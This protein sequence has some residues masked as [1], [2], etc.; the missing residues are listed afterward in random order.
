MSPVGESDSASEAEWGDLAPGQ[1]A[2]PV[3]VADGQA[4][5][6]LDALVSALLQGEPRA[7][8]RAITVVENATDDAARVLAAVAGHGDQVEVVGITGPPGAGKS[9]LTDALVTELRRRGRRVAV[10][11]VDPS[12]PLSGGAILGDRIRMLRHAEDEGVFVR[13]VAS[14]GHLGGLFQSVA[15]VLQ[16][17]AASGVDVVIVETVGAGQS[18]VEITRFAKT[19]VVVCDPGHGDDIQAMKAGILEIA[20]V[21]VVNKGDQ[22]GAQETCRQLQSMV[23]LRDPNLGPVAVLT[24]TATTGQGVAELVDAL[25]VPGQGSESGGGHKS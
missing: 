3:P 20:D 22:P 10:L 7:L 23:H 15:G 25:H 12:S 24:T 5:D 13:S 14:R 21:L 2:A 9:T 8:A 6:S 1:C 17:M 18:E 16:V 4:S 11:A 19:K